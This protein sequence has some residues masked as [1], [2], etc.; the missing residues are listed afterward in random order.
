MLRVDPSGVHGRIW[1]DIQHVLSEVQRICVEARAVDL[2]QRRRRAELAESRA[3]Q[4][5]ASG[6]ASEAPAVSSAPEGETGLLDSDPR[7]KQAETLAL[8]SEFIASHP[9]GEQVD[10][11][12]VRA[13]LRKML[14]WLKTRLAEELTEREV[15]HCLFPLVIYTDELVH[16][17][18]EGAA[19]RWEPLQGE[20]YDVDNGGEMFFA[21]LETLLHK[22]DTLPLI[23]EIYLF[24]LK[25]G[26][27]GQYH[28]Q[29]GKLTEFCRRVAERIPV[30][31]PGLGAGEVG[32]SRQVTLD[33][34]PLAHYVTAVLLVAGVFSLLMVVAHNETRRVERIWEGQRVVECCEADR[35]E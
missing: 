15:Y 29:P 8:R 30:A 14:G 9:I 35:C 11:V 34:F 28:G 5:F 2:L 17:A 10:L 21:A 12:T 3:L 26:F 13:Q 7:F 16:L 33:S 20:L 24:C 31:P 27:C 23:F 32:M 19:A 1:Y 6:R 25:D 18:T 22:S 4:G